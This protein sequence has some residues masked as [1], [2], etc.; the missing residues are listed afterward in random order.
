MSEFDEEMRRFAPHKLLS[1]FAKTKIVLFLVLA[2]A[3][4]V[5]VIGGTSVDYVY[6]RVVFPKKGELR[7]KARDALKTK[8]E[9][10][11]KKVAADKE[12]A[13]E[14]NRLARAAANTNTASTAKGP[15]TDADRM[16]AAKD[17]AVI[18][19]ITDTA[20]PEEMPDDPGDLGI[21]VEDTGF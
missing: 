19:R 12:A 10:H 1:I 3:I 20:K 7:D 13:A 4:H 16:D 9:E 15:L 8:E 18:K 17:T 21:T 14:S 2:L 6:Y 5:V 11:R